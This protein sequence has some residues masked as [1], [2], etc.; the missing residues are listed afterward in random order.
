MCQ[1]NEVEYL[2]NIHSKIQYLIIQSFPKS[3]KALFLE[4][5]WIK[6]FQPILFLLWIKNYQ[7]NYLN[8]K[9]LNP[10]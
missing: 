1:N 7:V 4:M 5:Y 8:V 2:L 9:N 3:P 6:T 10:E